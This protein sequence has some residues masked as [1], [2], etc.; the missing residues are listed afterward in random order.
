MAC[1]VALDRE[2]PWEVRSIV[3][4]VPMPI[5]GVS[6]ISIRGS[7]L[8]ISLMKEFRNYNKY[9]ALQSDFH[10][11]SFSTHEHMLVS[12]HTRY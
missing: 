12:S 8:F 11:H 7:L 6:G 1:I 3:Q 2:P 5:R 4:R 10:R 9:T